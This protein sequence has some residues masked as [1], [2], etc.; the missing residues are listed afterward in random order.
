MGEEVGT[1]CEMELEDG[2]IG[3]AESLEKWNGIRIVRSVGIERLL[4]GASW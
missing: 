1:C 2:L 4:R 3:E